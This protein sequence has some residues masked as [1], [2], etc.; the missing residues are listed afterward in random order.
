MPDIRKRRAI[1]PDHLNKPQ[2]SLEPDSRTAA[3][4]QGLDATSKTGAEGS[5]DGPMSAAD[6]WR[7]TPI[8]SNAGRARAAL[9]TLARIGIAGWTT[10]L[11]DK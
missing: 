6:L 11:R 8:T 9:A 4:C 5:R 7:L 1:A 2:A 10:K 3:T